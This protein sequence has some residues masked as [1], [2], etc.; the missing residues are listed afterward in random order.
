MCYACIFQSQDLDHRCSLH[1]GLQFIPVVV[2][3][4]TKNSHY[5]AHRLEKQKLASFKD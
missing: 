1:S 3:L 5:S 2:K 4:T